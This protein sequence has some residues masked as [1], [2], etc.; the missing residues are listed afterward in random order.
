MEKKLRSRIQKILRDDFKKSE[1]YSKAIENA[2]VD[3][4]LYKCNVCKKLMYTGVSEKNY[5]KYVE[6]HGEVEQA[7]VKITK[8]GRKSVKKCYDLDHIESVIPYDKY[9]YEITLDEWVER[10]HC[11]VNNLQVLCLNCHKEKTTEEKRLRKES[12][13]SIKKLDKDK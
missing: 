13:K 4:K 11:D 8:S 10:L 9:Y 6:I 3:S 7:E 12:K 1:L 5:Q 2:K